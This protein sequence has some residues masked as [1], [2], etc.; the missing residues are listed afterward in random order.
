MNESQK[1]LSDIVTY[2]KYAR[3][4]TDLKRRESWDEIIDRYIGMML[5]KYCG[6]DYS[7]QWKRKKVDVS[8]N[9]LAKEIIEN[10]KYLYD[11][12]VLPSMRALQFAGPAIEKTESRVYNCC[13]LPMNSLE[14][15]SELMFLLLGGTGVGY[16]VQFHHIR[17]L[18]EILKPSKQRKFLIGDSIEGWSDAVKALMKAYFGITRYK[19]RFD[20][21]DIREKGAQLVTAGGKAPG[22]D[23]LKIALTKIEALLNGKRDGDQ[24]TSLDVHDICCY[25]AD[26]VLAGGIRR[27]AM[28]SLFSFDDKEMATC[29]YGAWWDRNPQRGRANNSAV[30]VRN[31][32]KRKEFEEFWKI[33]K[34]SGSGEPGISFTDDPSYG[35][36]PCFTGDTLVA[37]ADGRNAVSIK[38]LA[39]E[40]YVGPV[41]TIDKGQV[42]IGYCSRVWK[43]REKSELVKVV[44]DDGSEIRCTPDHKFML[45]N[46]YYVAAKDLKPNTPLMPFNSFKRSDRDYRMI[47]SNSGRDLAQYRHIAQY[48]DLTKEGYNELHYHHKDG[49]GFNDH[50]SNLEIVNA[51]DHIREHKL[52]DKNP[53]HSFKNRDS[54]RKA[55]SEVRIGNKNPNY[56]GIT[57]DEIIFAVA[58][59][60]IQQNR[61]LSGREVLKASGLKS[62]SK[63]RLFE[64]GCIS[65]SDLGK[66]IYQ[67]RNHKV[68]SVELLNEKEDV[69]DLTV[70]GTHNFAVIS[71]TSDDQAITSSGIFVHNCHE[72]SLRPY[73]FCNLTEINAGDI[74]D[75]E[76][77]NNRAR[78][79]AFFGT[80]QAGFTDFHYLRPV[81]QNN[82]E[83]DALIGVGMT[84]IC[85]GDV[86]PLDLK[87]AANEVNKENERVAALIGINVAARTTTIKPS[88][89]TSC[90]VG[91]SSGIHAWH[92]EYYI[93]NMQCAIGDDLYNYFA[94]NHP[95]IIKEMD[96]QPGSAVIG[97]PMKAPTT[98]ILRENE[99]A[100]EFLERVRR[101]NEEWVLPGHQSGPNRNNVSATVSIKE[102]EWDEVGHWMWINRKGYSG[103]SVIP[104]DGGTYADAP[105]QDCSKYEYDKRMRY[106]RENP[107]VL[108]KIK[109][110][111]DNTNLKGELACVGGACELT[112]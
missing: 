16:S 83:K 29:K 25:I 102:D 96:F 56:S 106:I 43:T 84:G 112:Y 98:A 60:T 41:Y 46:G 40:G 19:P 39:E 107:I 15:F 111:I 76:D 104:Y 31:R 38:Q 20:Y 11:K 2:T 99:T 47:S 110:L 30:I 79:A 66:Q 6:Q 71:S 37:V 3:Y 67:R 77:L 74:R 85:N 91:T 100:L 32:V 17:E 55:N 103:I 4:R 44:L 8:K 59:Q 87:I 105:F 51:S 9:E 63:G 48:Y 33:I 10:S 82:T 45:R 86:L 13:Y 49:N 95:D 53:I 54:Y 62:F 52:G 94:D 22:P 70:E 97:V 72:I 101:F 21:S 27:A 93:R 89:T 23:P 80:L 18:P 65:P 26:A 57:S 34:A 61:Q 108:T 75:Q 58:Q 12:D 88:G 7:D 64:L 42:T 24:L 69:Y 28:I 36:N 5:K 109:E 78:V 14:S 35:F 50:I 73:S 92:S 90:V 68:V 81:W 1:L